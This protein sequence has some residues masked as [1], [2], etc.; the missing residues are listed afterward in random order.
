LTGTL[1]SFCNRIQRIARKLHT[2]KVRLS[3]TNMLTCLKNALWSNYF[4]SNKVT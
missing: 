2:F 1:Q 3:C 4:I